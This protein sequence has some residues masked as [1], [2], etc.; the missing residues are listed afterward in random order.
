MDDVCVYKPGSDLYHNGSIQFLYQNGV[1]ASYFYSIFGPEAEDQETMEL[2]GSKGRIIL[3]RHTGHLDLVPE[4]GEVH[5]EYDCR[6]E[7]FYDSHFGADMELIKEI[8]RFCDGTPP[9]VSARAGLEATR[10]VMG[11]FQSMDSGGTTVEMKEVPDA[12]L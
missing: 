7:N 4:Y 3:T 10:M 5:E 6:N 8:R 11:A 2:V 1:I 9:A 12:R